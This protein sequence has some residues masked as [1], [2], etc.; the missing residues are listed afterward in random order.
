MSLEAEIVTWMNQ[1]IG[2]A[3]LLDRVAYLLVSDYFLPLLMALWGVGLWF[4]GGDAA[5]RGANQRGVL[6]AAISLGFANLAVLLLNQRFFR[7][8]PFVDH[9]LT[10]LLYAPTDSSFPANP[11]A[12]AFAFAMAVCLKNRR[13]AVPLFLLATLWSLARV[14]NGLH[15]PSDVL[16]GALI[17]VAVACLVALGMRAIE[18]VTAR[19]LDAARRLHLA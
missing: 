13:A 7:D 19:V 14:Y 17:G 18:P 16:G 2:K 12:V 10:N 8:R 9:D 15:Y 11:S 1:G 3:Y 5:A 4:H 6:A